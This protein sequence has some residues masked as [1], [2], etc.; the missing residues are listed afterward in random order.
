VNYRSALGRNS[1]ARAAGI[2][3]AFLAIVV[4]SGCENPYIIHNLIRP[5]TLTAIEF[6]GDKE[7]TPYSLKPV[8]DKATTEYTVIV[9]EFTEKVYPNAVPEAG[10][11]VTFE[12]GWYIRDDEK[13]LLPLNEGYYDFPV[14][15]P[16]ITLRFTVWKD[17]RFDGEYTVSVRRRPD[18]GRVQS[19]SITTGYY[20]DDISGSIDSSNPS[21]PGWVYEPD[22][23]LKGFNAAGTKFDV[24]VPYNT[25]KVLIEPAA[26]HN[27]IFSYTLYSRDPA[28]YPETC[29]EIGFT[30]S[31][32]PQIFDFSNEYPLV[33]DTVGVGAAN[34]DPATGLKTA[35]LVVHTVS[36]TDNG[37]QLYPQDYTLKL[38]WER[39]YAY[40]NALHLQDDTAAEERIA[41]NFYM[42]NTGYDAEVSAAA[43][44][45]TVNAVPRDSGSTVTIEKWDFMGGTIQPGSVTGSSAT[46]LFP[47]AELSCAIKV[48]VNNPVL[49]PDTETNHGESSYWIDVRREQPLTKLVDIKLTGFVDTDGN[50]STPPVEQELFWFEKDN[51]PSTGRPDIHTTTWS[52]LKEP[53]VLPF[54]LKDENSFVL[55]L[56]GV[57]VSR[58]FLTG[59]PE[60][61]TC[62]VTYKAGDNLPRTDAGGI[63]YE[64]DF[65]GGT[66]AD[67]T[68]SR[69]GHKDRVYAITLI[70]T[71][72]MII[73]L[74]TDKREPPPSAGMPPDNMKIIND[75]E[76]GTFQSFA[77]S[78]RPVNSILPGQQVT[79]RLTPKLGWKLHELYVI[80]DN[81][82]LTKW[83]DVPAADLDGKIGPATANNVTEWKFNMPNKKLNFLLQYDFVTN[84][85]SR[86]AYVAPEGKASRTGAYGTGANGT[87]SGNTGTCWAYATSNLQG[88]IDKFDDGDFDEIWL[89]EG[90]Y[91]LDPNKDLNKDWAED[92][93]IA[94]RGDELNRSFVLKEGIRL[95][96]GY[97]GTENARISQPDGEPGRTA[98]RRTILSGRLSGSRNVRHVVTA[99]NIPAPAGQDPSARSNFAV[100]AGYNFTPDFD[101]AGVTLLDTLTIRDGLRTKDDG[102][103]TVNTKAVKNANG[104][105]FYNVDASPYL[106]NVIIANNTGVMG[107]GMYNEGAG[108]APVL[109]NVLFDNNDATGFY[110]NSGNG[111]GFANAGGMPV[112]LD[113]RFANNS[114]VG[115]DGA[116]LY[117]RGGSVLLR[118]CEFQYNHAGGVGG[119]IA[120]SGTTWIYG[121]TTKSILCSS[122]SAV[123]GGAGISQSG[124]LYL[125]NTTTENAVLNVGTLSGTNVTT[126]AGLSSGGS[127][128]L[129]NSTINAG[130]SVSEGPTVLTNVIFDGSSLS[131]WVN[132]GEKDPGPAKLGGVILT[133][134]TFKN[135]GSISTSY[136]NQYDFH[137][138]AANLLLNSVR[139]SG[140]ALNVSSSGTQY[141]D[142]R[143]GVYV[144]MNNVTAAGSGDALT[145]SA[146]NIAVP[147]SG[148]AHDILDLR[149]RNSVVMGSNDIPT[150]EGWPVIGIFAAAGSLGSG[151]VTL[152]KE[153]AALLSQGD[154]FRVL[155][156]N[157]TPRPA[158]YSIDDVDASTGVVSFTPVYPGSSSDYA[159]LANETMALSN[160]VSIGTTGSAVTLSPGT[161]TLSVTSAQKA[162]LPIN[163]VFK[164]SG[165]PLEGASGTLVCK[166]TAA[167]PVLNKITVDV[168]GTGSQSCAAEDH[169]MLSGKRS[170]LGPIG[171]RLMTETGANTWNLPGAAGILGSLPPPARRFRIAAGG[172]LIPG[173]NTVTAISG[174]DVT[175]T[176]TSRKTYTAGDR[177]MIP[178]RSVG[179]VNGPGTLSTLAGGNTW[180]VTNNQAVRFAVGTTFRIAVNAAGDLGTSVNTIESIT[181]NGSDTTIVFT[182]TSAD[183]Y[184]GMQRIMID[185][186]AIGGVNLPAK[187]ITAGS[188]DIFTDPLSPAQAALL[189]GKTFRIAAGSADGT[190]K[191]PVCTVT[192]VD[193]VTGKITF[194]ATSAASYLPGDYIV[195]PVEYAALEGNIEWD[196]SMARGAEKALGSA[197]FISGN[198]KTGAGVF[199][200]LADGGYRVTDSLLKNRGDSSLYPSTVS[201]SA[202][203]A[204]L[205]DLCFE[206]YD[207]NGGTTS[208]MRT[209]LTGL[210]GKLYIWTGT[211]EAGSLSTPVN[212]ST[213]LA[214][215]NGSNRGDLRFPQADGAQNQ[216]RKNGVID[217]GAY[218]N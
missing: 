99:A 157:G 164:I 184:F 62:S 65:S 23:H 5:V 73:E 98:A 208:G 69:P 17:H 120:N 170:S 197:T 64:F 29:A 1:T 14:D 54:D 77:A 115:G 66:S 102:T 31:R 10:S 205:L 4:F 147:A 151:T 86:V 67:I 193:T 165:A 126:N 171:A 204:D 51:N 143:S 200:S 194:T 186:G 145:T 199:D 138:G 41:G 134:V 78:G 30:D 88:V 203:I 96:G 76:R 213:F 75:S 94:D 80:E 45:I 48:V 92:I 85:V 7:E 187:T 185:A 121:T 206:Q 89:L 110:N 176:A 112:F 26:P 182:A 32:I 104:A 123:D 8:F 53:T 44:T 140:G 68:V 39:G 81:G 195:F 101:A 71:G 20:D 216:N 218:E 181:P 137:Q 34:T 168:F 83:N 50:P 59:F 136:A 172:K 70:R 117:V 160:W 49:F 55:E 179:T 52:A 19:L 74:Y 178:N 60:D 107:G 198:G 38:V 190:L 156:S 18:P 113:C 141:P 6:R 79:L 22:N 128:A 13:Q 152:R 63:P 166:V 142:G 47:A 61:P 95:Y 114:T 163:T 201:E 217:V 154:S 16:E 155:Q 28:Y 153:K 180:T 212:I 108:S 46:F 56:D 129:V 84:A 43:A 127:L 124:T 35:Y 36:Q 21:D 174:G 191:D 132:H 209:T 133:N 215:D 139:L 192:G 11:S 119:A 82:T 135:G 100:S 146:K 90:T 24:K 125:V 15:V 144:T 87:G 169:I 91:Y 183:P 188:N 118:G 173:E 131:Y 207:A 97:K 130:L 93:A 3:L 103:I 189:N 148:N 37:E 40:L 72:A 122:N 25:Q 210:F 9:H 106:R 202:A 2:A 150:I 162:L 175:F 33:G 12:S 159:Y 105:G 111:A 196:H 27:I 211:P 177:I 158:L 167:D 161:V 42:M 109:Q 116:G 58:L 214:N 57:K 149:I